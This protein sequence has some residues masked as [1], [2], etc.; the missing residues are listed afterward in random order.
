[1][2][3]IVLRGG[4]QFC[5]KQKFNSAKY[6]SPL[7]SSKL[8]KLFE[9]LFINYNTHFGDGLDLPPAH[10]THDN[11]GRGLSHLVFRCYTLGVDSPVLGF[12]LSKVQLA[13]RLRTVDTVIANTETV[14][15]DSR[16]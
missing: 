2:K 15:V 13:G 12:L 1:M 3:N 7:L 9:G 6:Y 5:N 8:T 14:A 16:Q 11:F 10:D 4:G